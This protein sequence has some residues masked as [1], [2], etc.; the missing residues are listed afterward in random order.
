MTHILTAE[1]YQGCGIDV[2][3]RTSWSHYPESTQK[4]LRVEA[5]DPTALAQPDFHHPEL[6]P[7][8]FLVGNHAD[9][10][11]PWVPVIATLCSASGYLSIPCC[12]WTFDSR[13][14]RSKNTPYA[15]GLDLDKFSESLYLGG[16]GSN[17]SSYSHYRIWLAS[18]S[19][20]CGWEVES[21][22]L[23]IP[24]TRNWALIGTPLSSIDP[25]FR[26]YNAHVQGDNTS[27]AHQRVL[28]RFARTFLI[29]LTMSRGGACSR[30]DA[31][32]EKQETTDSCATSRI[33]YHMHFAT[34]LCTWQSSL[35]QRR[36]VS[37]SM[38]RERPTPKS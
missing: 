16:D 14:E 1:G 10:L 24:S 31:L 18:L 23:R 21:E 27:G 12:A 29:S 20:H 38:R 15:T 19:F 11:T 17:A 34:H 30:Q 22:M 35:T 7:G 25:Q 28:S 33:I 26:A 5:L 6:V 36:Y 9:E 32:K 3:A 13:Y 2:R 8:V 37:A 4:N